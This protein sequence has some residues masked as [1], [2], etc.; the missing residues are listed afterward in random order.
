MNQQVQVVSMA[1][2][3]RENFDKLMALFE[4]RHILHRSF[5]EWLVDAEIVRKSKEANGLRVVCVDIDPDHFFEWCLA[6]G[7]N[8][9]AQA[10]IDYASMVADKVVTGIESSN[11][12][13]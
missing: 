10:R 9:N 6:G 2:Y 5:D 11:V 1:W 4:D 7:L 12:E 13:Q 8:F 3:K